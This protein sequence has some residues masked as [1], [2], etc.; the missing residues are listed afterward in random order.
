MV[1][2]LVRA[3]RLQV[4]FKNIA[5]TTK[6]SAMKFLA[7]FYLHLGLKLFRLKIREQGFC[8]Q[9]HTLIKHFYGMALLLANEARCHYLPFHGIKAILFG[10][11]KKALKRKKEI[12]W[13]RYPLL[14]L[15]NTEALPRRGFS[16]SCTLAQR[17]PNYRR[18]GS[19][20]SPYLKLT[21]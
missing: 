21:S 2:T 3:L 1:N 14:Q 6:S 8:A 7:S 16:G 5:D 20:Y 10:K 12:Y 17:K 4:R 13:H 11:V 15:R 9:K 19:I 18:R